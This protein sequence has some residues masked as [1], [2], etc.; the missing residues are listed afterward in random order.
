MNHGNYWGMNMI[1]WFV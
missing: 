1:W